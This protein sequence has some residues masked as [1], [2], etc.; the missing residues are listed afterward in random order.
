[1]INNYIAIGFI[2]IMVLV[3]LCYM[4]QKNDILDKKNKKWYI[5]TVMVTMVIILAELGTIIFE[6]TN[7]RFLNNV[8]NVLGFTLSPF[9]PILMIFVFQLKIKPWLVF[10]CF[11]NLIFSVISPL[12]GIMFYISED[13][14]YQRGP[15]F[16]FFVLSYIYGIG[17]LYIMI[18]KSSKHH[19]NGYL[20][21]Q[22]LTL[23]IISGT[24]IQVLNPYIHTTWLCVTLALIVNYVHIS[25]YYSQYDRLTFLGNR[26]AYELAKINFEYL[27]EGTIILFDVDK[28][29]N[30][31]DTFGHQYGDVCLNKIGI[32]IKETFLK[33]GE[34][35][36]IGGDEFCVLSKVT[37]EEE[38]EAS[39]SHLMKEINRERKARKHFPTLSYGYETYV[40][41]S[42]ITMDEVFREAD[43]KLYINKNWKKE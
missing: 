26:R 28:F 14:I 10:P 17:L 18:V 35:Y 25:E 40:K 21:Y 5:F 19:M 6:G 37:D 12:L 32:A 41:S 20:L 7:H 38:L 33:L 8:A 36:R 4:V 39:L 43:R 13:N 3:L 16:W 30:V 27:D 11:L 29:K 42:G 9:I 1:M 31:N 15:L 22:L 23:F 24:T 2:N 34:G